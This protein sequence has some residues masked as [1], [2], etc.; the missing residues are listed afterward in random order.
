MVK[1]GI[2]E[3]ICHS[4]YGSAKANNKYMKDYDK[5]KE[6]SDLQYWDVNNLYGR[7]MSQ[8]F[9]INNFESI[10]ASQFIEDFIKKTIMKK[11]MKDIFL[12]LMFNILKNCITFTM[13]HHF[14]LKE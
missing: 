8:T 13:A 10:D 1:K 11:V 14:Y 6:S 12:K 5:N 4:I 3:G 7:A 2:R 9:P